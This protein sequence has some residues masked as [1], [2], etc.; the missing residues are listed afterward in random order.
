M[1][2]SYQTSQ[3]PLVQANVPAH[4]ELGQ[5]ADKNTASAHATLRE[6]QLIAILQKSKAKGESSEVEE[7]KY[8]LPVDDDDIQ[9]GTRDAI[10]LK[11]TRSNE[12]AFFINPEQK[13][14]LQNI[15][16]IQTANN[17]LRKYLPTICSRTLEIS[18]DK[19]TKIYEVMQRIEK[20]LA[21]D[22]E[23]GILQDE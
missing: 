7:E 10:D 2:L 1:Y 13:S 22:T 5:S 18:K 17:I 11:A 23:G 12:N 8:Y 6:E 9:C 14:V 15:L 21:G 4:G 3:A 19:Q 16:F 20:F